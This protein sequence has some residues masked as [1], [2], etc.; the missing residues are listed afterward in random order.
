MSQQQTILVVGLVAEDDAPTTFRPPE[1]FD[2]FEYRTI[3]E[4]LSRLKNDR[5]LPAR[6]MTTVETR[7][8]L[9]RLA[10]TVEGRNIR[11]AITTDERRDN[12]PQSVEALA[13]R[14]PSAPP[15]KKSRW[16]ASQWF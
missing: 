7:E 3:F 13:A 2:D 5:P 16:R 12:Q 10:K 6:L 9:L 14:L 8:P 1:A 4:V 11:L 15:K